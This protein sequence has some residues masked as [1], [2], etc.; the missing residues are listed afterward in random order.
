MGRF[1]I[2]ITDIFDEDGENTDEVSFSLYQDETEG[3]LTEA[4]HYFDFLTYFIESGNMKKYAQIW[5]KG[6][7]KQRVES[8]EVNAATKG[9]VPAD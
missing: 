1:V 7:Q 8:E 5:A 9:P 6:V 4:R 3:A 2:E